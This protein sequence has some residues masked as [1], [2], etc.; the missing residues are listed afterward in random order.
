M[1]SL[2][3]DAPLEQGPKAKPEAIERAID[4]AIERRDLRTAR[5]LRE[6]RAAR[7][8]A[9]IESAKASDRR[10]R[11][12]R[13]AGRE[14]WPTCGAPRADGDPCQARTLWVTGEDSP[15]T[16]C[17]WHGGDASPN[18]TRARPASDTE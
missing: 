17:R 18:I 2:R 4:E 13:R 16:R 15:R 11:A 1:T 14:T 6:Q 10:E 12:K 3:R 7:V 5:A 9:A 8:R